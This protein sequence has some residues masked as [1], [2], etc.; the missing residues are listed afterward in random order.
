MLEIQRLTFL[1]A[2]PFQFVVH[3][4]SATPFS[5]SYS[6]DGE[7][8]FITIDVM[9]E[10]LRERIPKWYD[11]KSSFNQKKGGLKNRLIGKRKKLNM[12]SMYGRIETAA[13]GIAEAMHYIHGE[14]I[15]V[16]D[17]KPANIGFHAETGKVCLLDFGFARE[18]SLCADEEICGTPRYMAPEVLKG[19]GYS[20]KTDVY[21]FGII[22]HE[23]VSL[24]HSW[25]PKKRSVSSHAE[26]LTAC[27]T[28]PKPSTENIP[29]RNI[30][31]L[32]EDCISDDPESRPDFDMIC[33]TLREVLGSDAPNKSPIGKRPSLEIAF[34]HLEGHHS[35][36]TLPINFDFDDDFDTDELFKGS[37]EF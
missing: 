6:D 32:I 10:T 7:G 14:G 36:S 21:S 26:L 18:L 16:R 33:M 28:L 30:A 37:S 22:L 1:I 11:N 15:I 2:I 27:D 31:M 24:E 5:S 20:L 4:V 13:L 35:M 34:E 12:N 23:I 3:G 8:F 9:S 25:R 17:L 29:C 19:E